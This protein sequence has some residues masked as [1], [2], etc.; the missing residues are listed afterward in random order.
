MCF[1][2]SHTQNSIIMSGYKDPLIQRSTHANGINNGIV[3]SC[4][5]LRYTK[6]YKIVLVV[7]IMII[8]TPFI[9]QYF[10]SN[11]S[12]GQIAYLYLDINS[13]IFLFCVRRMMRTT[14]MLSFIAIKNHIQ[15]HMKTL[16]IS[17]RS[18]LSYG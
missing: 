2:F 13:L 6:M 15:I 3:I 14:R 4:N 1:K 11:V 17:K 18:I 7:L 9:V 5:F 8:L 16:I 10:V 12:F